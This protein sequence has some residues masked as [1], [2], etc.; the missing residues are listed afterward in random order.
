MKGFA[1]REYIEGSLDI[2]SNKLDGK[3]GR[4]I[5]F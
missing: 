1:P 4:L 2:Y 5:G 3:V